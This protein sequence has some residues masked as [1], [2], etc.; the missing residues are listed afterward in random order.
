MV[1][2]FLFAKVTARENGVN[3]AC[4]YHVRVNVK[5]SIISRGAHGAVQDTM[6]SARKGRRGGLDA[7]ARTLQRA[8]S[9]DFLAITRGLQ[10]FELLSSVAKSARS[11]QKKDWDNRIRL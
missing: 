7:G 8:D 1:R 2:R 6:P 9:L 4:K 10:N 5:R 11:S 3:F